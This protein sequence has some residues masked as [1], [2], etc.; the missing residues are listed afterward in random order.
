[1]KKQ[2]WIG[3]FFIDLSRNQITRNKYIQTIPPKA[4]AVLTYLAE[5]RGSVMSQEDILASVWLDTVVSPN[6]LQKNIAQLRKALGDDGKDQIYIKTHAKQ[7][8][9]LEC[10]VRWQDD[11]NIPPSNLDLAQASC[12]DSVK[13]TGSSRFG[14]NTIIL[15]IAIII[16]A[17]LGYKY[18]ESTR[19]SPLAI[20]NIRLLTATDDKEFDPGYT[21]DG[22]FI[23]FNRYLEKTCVNKLWAKDMNSQREMQ[24]TKNWGAYGR[25]SFSKDGKKMVFLATQPCNEPVVQRDCY[26]L[27]SLDFEKALQSPQS[28]EVIL[29]C[30]N[31]L[32]K[33]P[34]WLNNGDVALLQNNSDRWKLISY[35]IRDNKSSDLYHIKDGNLV[36]FTYSTKDDLIAVT[37]IHSD[38][39]Q[40]I[41]MLKPDGRI[42]SSHQIEHSK[43]IPK[44]RQIYPSFDPLNEQLVFTTGRQL[45]TLSYDGKVAKVPLS[46]TERMG[47]PEFHPS[48]KKLLML[49]GPY[50]SDI[51]RLNLDQIQ[52]IGSSKEEDFSYMSFERTN[53]REN[54]AMFQP[55]GDSIAFRSRRSGEEQVW[56]SDGNHPKQLTHFPVDTD[57]HGMNWAADGNSLLVNA[58]NKLTQ[59]SLD[60]SQKAFPFRYPVLILY[61]WNSKNNKALLLIRV[62]GKIKFV[63]Y[64]LNSSQFRELNDK[65]I[66]WALKSE[67]GQ[68]IYKDHLDQ[69]W[70]PGPVEDRHIAEL[71]Q[72][73]RRAKSFVLHDNVIYAINSDDQLWSYNLV[74]D[75]FSI[76]GKVDRD[77]DYLTDVRQSEF[78]MTIEVAA[79]KEVVE[80]SLVK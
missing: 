23:V 65:R 19:T 67:N 61:Q 60:S 1:M 58:N 52:Q 46:S 75:S 35:S 13:T 62:Q 54:N 63:E 39:Q 18:L 27:V 33:R 3:S 70:Q 7:G 73:G 76:V 49:K 22:Q 4:L 68:L 79:K 55:G 17:V 43:Y 16:L 48:G 50:D 11:A 74:T 9:S 56:I 20:E 32:V 72:Q 77:V 37:S 47:Q 69:F 44:F 5:N 36:S 29:Q 15:P 38:G 28:P 53:L 12:I 8:Y 78:L 51:V 2:Y 41:E 80:L 34:I 30:K 24:L 57:I 14:I 10:D 26:D 25:H 64:D 59:V 42:V 66:I 40:Y 21:P 45:F 71:D 31:S 6:T